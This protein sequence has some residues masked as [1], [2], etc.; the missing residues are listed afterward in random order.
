MSGGGSGT[1]S[2][3]V[4]CVKFG[5]CVGGHVVAATRSLSAMRAATRSLY[6]KVAIHDV[7]SSRRLLPCPQSRGGGLSSVGVRIVCPSVEV[8]SERLTV[9]VVG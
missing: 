1:S 2:G 8:G 9:G 7:Q 3:G 5:V 4:G 6:S